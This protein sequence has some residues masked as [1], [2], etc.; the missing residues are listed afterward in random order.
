MLKKKCRTC[1]DE[2]FPQYNSLQKY[3]GFECW[4]ESDKKKIAKVSNKRA[5]QN[6][7]YELL[8]KNYLNSHPRCEKC[9]DKATEIHHKA[10]RNGDRL[11]D[12]K[13]FMATCRDCHS[14]I[15]TH[16]KESRMLGWLK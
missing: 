13:D 5:S 8:R 11:C 12:V 7:A 9:G 16:P 14:W 1:G 6:K 4:M 3:C 10:G 15:H 2:F